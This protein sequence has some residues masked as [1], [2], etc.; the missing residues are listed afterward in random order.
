[1][2]K[3]LIALATSLMITTSAWAGEEIKLAAAIGSGAA[4]QPKRTSD[5]NRTV[6]AGET[7]AGA[8]S[9]STMITIG[10]VSAAALAAIANS[11][12]SSGH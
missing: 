4:V 9:T 10:V 6:G 1:M 7:A 3:I 5:A 11:G 2:K 12:S 8:V